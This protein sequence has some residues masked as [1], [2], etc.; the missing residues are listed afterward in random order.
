MTVNVALL[1]RGTVFH[2][3]LYL[4]CYERVA[5]AIRS[6]QPPVDAAD[7]RRGLE[8]LESARADG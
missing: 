4:D 7:A 1:G 3:P 2:A 8:I 5:A 6:A